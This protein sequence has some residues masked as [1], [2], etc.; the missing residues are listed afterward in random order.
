MNKDELT[1][2]VKGFPD[3]PGI[4]MMRDANGEIIYIG[5]AK[6]LKKRV[7]S[8]FRHS[9]F[10]S[11]RLR[12]LVDTIRDISTIRTESEIEA[13]I[14]ENRM[15]KLYQPF[16]NVDLKMNER[17]A[18]IKITAEKY[19]KLVVTRVKMDDGAVYIGPYVRVQ[20][21][22][23]LLRLVERYL[24]LRSCAGDAS[25]PPNGRPCM[26]YSL[27]RCL[28]PCCGLCT[29]N[30]YRDRVADV[31]LLLQ[32][33]GA[34]LV[35]R[36]RA[37]MDKA[38]E[39]LCF[40]ESAHLRD[41]IR[42]IWRVSRQQHTTPDIP[43]GEDN[44]WD[45]LN[46]M[47]KTFSLPLLP[48]RID[49]FDIS[50][51]AGNYTVGVAVVFEQGYPNPSLYRKFNIKTVEGIDDFRS[52]KETLTRRY[53]RC[54]KGEEPLPQLI[55]IDGGPVQLDFALQAL[56]SLGLTN[57]PVISLAKEFEEVYVPNKKEPV[58]LELTDPVLRLLQHVRDE[59]HRFAVTSHRARR[60]QSLKRS[61]IEEVPG[62]G[63]AKAAMLITR[64]GSVKAITE[65]RPEELAAAPGIGPAL[66]KR[67]LDKLKEESQTEVPALKISKDEGGGENVDK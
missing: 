4:Y 15:I 32:G 50:H 52:M 66:A 46:S 47:Q 21:V 51:I 5:K 65:L 63:R 8:Y 61:R 30:E 40:E 44:F 1:S 11:P 14:L 59:A 23:A 48:W 67:I 36:L 22:R 45:I 60:A 24:P 37:R 27:G 33:Q 58:R 25:R 49:G 29:P 41:T 53:A 35:E 10:A 64:F 38:A 26:K 31:V 2:F 19:P 7:L 34:E 16:F 62:I 13:L 28:A 39:R 6:S 55:L 56:E 20:E 57:I 42:A 17:Y 9:N 43:T 54:L 12:K 3:K 18:Y